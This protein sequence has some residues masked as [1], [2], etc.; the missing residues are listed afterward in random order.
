MAEKYVRIVQK[1]WPSSTSESANH[2][3]RHPAFC[4]LLY[5]LY[6]TYLCV[7]TVVVFGAVLLLEP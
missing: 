7:L 2:L 3:K 6:F 1:C 4:I 5:L